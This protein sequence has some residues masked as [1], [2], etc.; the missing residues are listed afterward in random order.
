[1]GWAYQVSTE[2]TWNLF[3][4]RL[5]TVSLSSTHFQAK[6]MINHTL[7]VKVSHDEIFVRW[8]NIG[9]TQ[10]TLNLAVFYSI[11]WLNTISQ[12]IKNSVLVVERVIIVLKH[13]LIVVTYF[14]HL[15]HWIWLA[16]KLIDRAHVS[17]SLILELN[18]VF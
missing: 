15:H 16:I 14:L 10:Y 13:H 12:F 18:V 4:S 11:I 5:G 7:F 17:L 2:K 3:G 6:L 1:M 9:L 8:L